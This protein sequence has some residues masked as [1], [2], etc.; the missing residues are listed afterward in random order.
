M[1][2]DTMGAEE[3]GH[4]MRRCEVMEVLTGQNLLVSLV[5]SPRKA[6]GEMTSPK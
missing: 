1:A 2:E 4:E 5:L 6:V 3:S